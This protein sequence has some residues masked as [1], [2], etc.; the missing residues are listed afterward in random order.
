[1]IGRTYPAAVA[2]V[3]DAQAVLAQ[4][5]EALDDGATGVR[6]SLE[7]DIAKGKRRASSQAQEEMPW[8][9]MA[10]IQRALPRDAF[11]TNDASTANGWA[12][13]HL[14]RYLPRTFNITGNMA[15]LGYAFP[16]AVGA[17][18]AYPQR[19]AVAI[20]GDGGFLFTAYTLATAFR[21]RINAVVVVFDDGCYGTIGRAQLREFGRTIGAELRNPDF[22]ALAQAYG[23]IGVRAEGPDQIYD[24]LLAAWEEELPTVIHVPVAGSA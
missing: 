23:A 14:E 8:K 10:A 3:G 17:K 13:R 6:P 7:A 18:L 5:L 1:V 11:V 4:L 15:A 22:V 21:Y 24:A 19:Q 2:L 9:Y 20:M 12:A 16:A